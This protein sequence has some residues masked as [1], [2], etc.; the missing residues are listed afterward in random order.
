MF[1]IAAVLQLTLEFRWWNIVELGACIALICDE[2]FSKIP[3]A[4]R[5]EELKEKQE[6]I[7]MAC[8][9][10]RKPPNYDIEWR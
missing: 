4:V 9:F 6:P 8:G 7:Y 5:I 1:L 3:R 10:I 2:I